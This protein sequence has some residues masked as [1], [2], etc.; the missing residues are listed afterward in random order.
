MS[1]RFRNERI[2]IKLTKEEKEV[3]EKKMRLA[4]CKTM[5]HFLR[6]CVL[7]KE[8]YVVDLEPFRNLQWLLSNV[9]NNINQIAKRVNSTG[10]IYKED[11]NDMKKEIEH[12]SKELWQIHSLLL[13]RTS[14]GD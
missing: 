6:K 3:F 2:E 12:F 4:N 13:N 10:I 1:N 7:E 8:I 11:I 9:T 5:S 14:G